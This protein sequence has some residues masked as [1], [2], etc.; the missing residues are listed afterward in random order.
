MAR[1][2]DVAGAEERRA[3]RDPTHPFISLS[4]HQS[5]RSSP[6][7]SNRWAQTARVA[8]QVDRRSAVGHCSDTVAASARDQRV[9]R[10]SGGRLV[11][12]VGRLGLPIA[13]TAPSTL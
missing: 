12:N 10:L 2:V 1:H 8:Y 9:A 6:G 5:P 11:P 13:M 3:K 7:V 4:V